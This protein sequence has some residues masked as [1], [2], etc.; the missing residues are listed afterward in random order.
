M[1]V[2]SLL[3]LLIVFVVGCASEKALNRSCASSV[4][5]SA[6]VFDNPSECGLSDPDD[7]FNGQK[8]H[9]LVRKHQSSSPVTVR[10]GIFPS[11]ASKSA[12]KLFTVR[13]FN[14]S[15]Q[16]GAIS[17]NG[18]STNCRCRISP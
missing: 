15:S 7:P 13:P 14:G 16:S 18:T 2:R 8:M 6:V 12:S 17:F 1:I 5:V 4:R 11:R 3:A 10:N 9:A